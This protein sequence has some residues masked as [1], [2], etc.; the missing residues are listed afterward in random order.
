MEGTTEQRLQR[1]AR[2]Y[3]LSRAR[4]KERKGP[5][6]E[7]PVAPV[8]KPPRAVSEE[9]RAALQAELREREA[10]GQLYGSPVCDVRRSLRMR[11]PIGAYL[12]ER[13]TVLLLAVLAIGAWVFAN[14]ERSL[15]VEPVDR[16]VV[17]TT[18]ALARVLPSFR[19]Q[20]GLETVEK[21]RYLDGSHTISSRYDEP[22]SGGVHLA[23]TTHVAPSA[24]AARERFRMTNI[25]TM[26]DWKL[27]GSEATGLTVLDMEE[28]LG[29]QARVYQVV[30]AGVPVGYSV[31]FQV[32]RSVT[33]LALR[34]IV[35][36]S[37][38]QLEWLLEPLGENLHSYEP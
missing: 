30:R 15:P 20:A 12:P 14:L 3:E 28:P 10:G 33:H 22:G 1:L 11:L 19:P 2:E 24:D 29:D 5:R 37:P 6:A 34:G 18:D 21:T 26:L 4:K 38:V 23:S 16:T 13:G 7:G 32:D 36:D 8:S 27:D 17:L 35:F 31:T 9:R 25:D